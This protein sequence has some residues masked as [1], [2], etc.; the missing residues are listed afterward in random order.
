M[1]HPDVLSKG[2]LI[3]ESVLAAGLGGRHTDT[4]LTHFFHAIGDYKL[5]KIII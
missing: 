1:P 4:S 5:F 2:P 3:S